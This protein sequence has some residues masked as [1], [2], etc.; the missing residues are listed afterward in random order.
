MRILTPVSSF[1]P[2]SRSKV[3]V[4]LSPTP[5]RQRWRQGAAAGGAGGAAD[6]GGSGEGS[7]AAAGAGAHEESPEDA[8]E[9]R[10]PSRLSARIFQRLG[11]GEGSQY[12]LR[13]RVRG[14]TGGRGTGPVA[15]NNGGG[16]G[17]D[18]G[19]GFV[20]LA[21]GEVIREVWSDQ[22]EI[23]E[24]YSTV[25]W[26]GR[27]IVL[28]LGP[29]EGPPQGGGKAAV[30][31]KKAGKAKRG[32]AGSRKAVPT[33]GKRDRA[34]RGGSS[35][36]VRRKRRQHDAAGRVAGL[37]AAGGTGAG[38]LGSDMVGGGAEGANVGRKRPRRVGAAGERG[39]SG[40][41]AVPDRGAG[42][43]MAVEAARRAGGPAEE[44]WDSP[45]RLQ[46]QA[47]QQ[48]SAQEAA[49][50]AAG[51]GGDTADGGA[52]SGVLC[53]AADQGG[54][55]RSDAVRLGPGRGPAAG[56]APGSPPQVEQAP[57]GFGPAMAGGGVG[58]AA[59]GAGELTE[60]GRRGCV[61]DF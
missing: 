46:V 35:A 29:T 8:A 45:R 25:W 17:G 5:E 14:N 39:C 10:T 4:H 61:G 51:A 53:G 7:G 59:A 6:A 15:D 44:R 48:Q 26:E 22:P 31:R 43:D 32:P 3:Q 9:D 13:R 24:E 52:G 20:V 21:P 30:L 28:E 54:M 33:L 23:G 60:V 57:G 47:G 40:D 42:R 12:Q 18:A 19:D 58:Q 41:E 2:R 49:I 16:S 37:Q 38:P 55:P 1:N 27:P 50:G 36:G 34:I 11:L 56:R